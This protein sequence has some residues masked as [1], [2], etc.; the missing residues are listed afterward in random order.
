M[1]ENNSNLIIENKMYNKRWIKCFDQKNR[2][3]IY[4]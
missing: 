4:N 1:I 2:K 3:K